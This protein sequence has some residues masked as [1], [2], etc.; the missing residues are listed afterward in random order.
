MKILFITFDFLDFSMR[1]AS[2]LAE[3]VDV[4]LMMPRA[5]AQPFPEVAQSESEFSTLR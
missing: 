3:H 4:C 2:A 1:L 5:E